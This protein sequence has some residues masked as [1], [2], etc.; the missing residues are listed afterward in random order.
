MSR[1]SPR[2][3]HVL[4]LAASAAS[5]L[6]GCSGPSPHAGG[7][8]PAAGGSSA[9]T[10]YD[11]AYASASPQ[12]TLD[13]YLPARAAGPAPLVIWVHG[14]GWRTGDKSSIA[15]GY[16]PSAPP[17][18]AASCTEIVQVQ[19]PDLAA[20]TAKGY[21]VA[22]INYRL[23]RNP[24]AAV[25]DAKAAV[26]FLR[27]NA[28]R[29]HLDP[30]RFAAWGDSAGGYTVIMLGVTG[31][32]H[33]EFDD[34]ALGNSGV[35]ATVQ[36][37]VDWFGPTDAASMP[38]NVG[39]AESPY[40]YL[41]AGQSLPPFMIAHGY[42]DCIVPVQQSRHLHAALTKAG[43][44]ATLTVLPGANHEDPAFMRTRLAPTVAFL[45]H[46]FGR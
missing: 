16:H 5:A 42:A 21:A 32:Q 7:A 10:V 18:S 22:A 19:T 44:A 11:L 15:A 36:A 34:P 27:T 17:P 6:A 23:T 43:G 2:R 33:T 35:P 8:T 41:K 31:G 1:Y 9:S 46:T 4:L 30:D 37:V 13:L 12:E 28:G 29:Y 38:G 20:L 40:T 45:D 25:Q 26:R 14:G 24:V 3:R 39:A